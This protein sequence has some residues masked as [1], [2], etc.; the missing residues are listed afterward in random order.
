MCVCVCV[1]SIEMH[2]KPKHINKVCADAA[3]LSI[4]LA[5]LSLQMGKGLTSCL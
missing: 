1:Y 4:A 2:T 5:S 3:I